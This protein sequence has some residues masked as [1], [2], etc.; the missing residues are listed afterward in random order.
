MSEGALN[1]LSLDLNL[2]SYCI[3][4]LN[5]KFLIWTSVFLLTTED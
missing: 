2:S 4:N 5:L 1:F 3:L